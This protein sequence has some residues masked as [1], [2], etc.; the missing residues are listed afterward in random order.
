VLPRRYRVLLWTGPLIFISWLSL[1]FLDPDP[2]GGVYET[3][4]L[5]YFLGSLFGHATLAAAWAALGPGPLLWRMPLSLVWVTMLAVAIG[6][7]VGVN[8]G[9]NEAPIVI[10]S[11]LLGQWLLLQLPLW[12]LALGFKL[13]LRHADE[14]NQ[15]FDPR[16]WQFGIRQLIITTAIVGVVFG[17]GRLVVTNLSER[18]NLV[19]G[20]G[21]IFIFLAL[22]A[23]VLTLPLLLAALMR[24]WALPGALVVLVLIGAATAWELPLL[25]SVHK[26]A[27]P[28]TVDLAA[29]NAFTAA[30][31]LLVASGVRLSGYSLSRQPPP[32]SSGFGATP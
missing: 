26:G 5:G 20:E 25:Q 1:A 19:S 12:A 27:G 11:C 18:L 24:R 10:G 7:N 21:P 6:I 16:Q 15:G 13:H 29:I 28:G 22:A 2:G 30:V 14:L 17:I 31:V 8:G 3:I 23:I 9:P 32:A 4:V